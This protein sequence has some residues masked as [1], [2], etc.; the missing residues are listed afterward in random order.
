[1]LADL[2][3]DAARLAAGPGR[4]TWRSIAAALLFDNGFQAV[5]FYRLARWFKAND[6]PFLG[7]LLARLGLLLTGAELSPGAEIGP[8]LRIAHG[9]GL[10]V[11]GYARIGTDALLLHGVTIGS[12]S[13]ERVHEMPVVGD[14]AFLG[15]GSTLIGAVT[16]GSDVTVGVGAIVA[17]RIAVG[18]GTLIGP[19]ALVTED[20]PAGSRVTSTAGLAVKP[21]AGPPTGSP[22]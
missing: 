3:R 21:R 9:V 19:G 15:A 16:L 17:G 7:P 18:D 22:T 20:V 5:L 8:G 2:K 10:V 4:P 1:M 11:G 6:I 13:P 14:R 12:P